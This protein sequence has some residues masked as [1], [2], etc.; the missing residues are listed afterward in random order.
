MNKKGLQFKSAFFAVI[1]VS[2]AFIAVGVWVSDWN[3][4]YSS[5]LTYDLDEYSK[6]EETSEQASSQQGNVSIKSSFAADTDFEGT[7][8][9]GVFGVLNN[10]YAPFRVVFGDGGM[11]DSVTERWGLPD[12]IRQ[13]FVTMM[14]IAITFA[15]VAI[16]F[17][18]PVDRS[19]ITKTLCPDSRSLSDR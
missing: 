2:M 3:T 7:S 6:L 5:G 14:I 8:I 19:S 13:G 12:Y 17:R 16:F 18:L 15:L 1:L 4:Q 10:I 9:R 11:L